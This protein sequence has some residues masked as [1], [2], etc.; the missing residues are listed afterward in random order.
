M[1]NM[2]MDMRGSLN[3]SKFQK[4]P[5]QPRFYGKAMINGVNFDIKGWEKEGKDGPWI[6]LLFE[7][8]GEE[9]EQKKSEPDKQGLFSKPLNPVRASYVNDDPDDIPF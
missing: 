7:E 8:T 4:T 2:A 1:M 5:Q 6:S 3:V 9:F